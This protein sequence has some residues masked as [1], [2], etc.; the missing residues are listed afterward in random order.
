MWDNGGDGKSVPKFPLTESLYWDAM[1]AKWPGS[2]IRYSTWLSDDPVVA[3]IQNALVRILGP[4]RLGPNW[5]WEQPGKYDLQTMGALSY[6]QIP[7][8]E[9]VM[10]GEM[11]QF[12]GISYGSL[13]PLPVRP[14]GGG[15]D[16]PVVQPKNIWYILAAF[17]GAFVTYQFITKFI[18]KR[19]KR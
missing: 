12:L 13:Y 19:G 1:R 15:S 10:T 16:E 8:P 14:V 6:L 5:T 11:Y 4:S 17:S 7:T 2:A 9:G 3:E 18:G